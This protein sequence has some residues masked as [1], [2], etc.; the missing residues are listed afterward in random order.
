MAG[1]LTP[2]EKDAVFYEVRDDLESAANR[3]SVSRE[4]LRACV[5][6]IPDKKGNVTRIRDRRLEDRIKGSGLYYE[7]V[8]GLVPVKSEHRRS[9]VIHLVPWKRDVAA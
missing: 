2:A 1:L 5:Q 9:M 3:L 4:T 8:N 6:G 7:A